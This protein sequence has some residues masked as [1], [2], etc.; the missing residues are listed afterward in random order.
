[1][2]RSR[3]VSGNRRRVW[4][5]GTGCTRNLCGSR[6]KYR[7]W[8]KYINAEYYI[9][10]ALHVTVYLMSA[11]SGITHVPV[12]SRGVDA[13]LIVR[14]PA[15]FCPTQVKPTATYCVELPRISIYV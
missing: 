6:R 15:V 1:M 3:A 5:V 4:R 9:L 2:S 13:C 10:Y 12:I 14:S 7:L 8:K 11:T